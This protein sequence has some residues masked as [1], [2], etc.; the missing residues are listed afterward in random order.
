MLVLTRPKVC[1]NHVRE[2]L[3]LPIKEGF[4]V[5]AMQQFSLSR[6]NAGEFLEVRSHMKR[7]LNQNF[8]AMKFTARHVLCW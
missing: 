8:L 7:I 4:E 3:L 6:V 2:P 5:S 1:T